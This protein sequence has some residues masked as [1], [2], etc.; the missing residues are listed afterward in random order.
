MTVRDVLMV[1]EAIKMETNPKAKED[2]VIAEVK[3]KEAEKVKKEDLLSTLADVCEQ[4]KAGRS[5]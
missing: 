1:T 5:A 3:F 4:G 2:S